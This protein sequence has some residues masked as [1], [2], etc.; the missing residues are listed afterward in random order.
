MKK[1]YIKPEAQILTVATE[2]DLL[3]ISDYYADEGFAKH[4]HESDDY[5][6]GDQWEEDDKD[7]WGDLWA[8]K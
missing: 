5:T 7:N 1:T 4:R 2:N 3:T 6:W 8:K